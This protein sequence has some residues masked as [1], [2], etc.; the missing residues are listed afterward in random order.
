[1]AATGVKKQAVGSA[2]WIQSEKSEAARLGSEAVEEFGFS[3]RNELDWLNE[4][5]MEIFSK[6]QMYVASHIL[7]DR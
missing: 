4:H 3:V 6:D 5:M 1:M 2:G 7:G